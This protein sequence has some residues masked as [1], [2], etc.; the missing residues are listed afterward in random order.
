MGAQ[1]AGPPF[2]TG[3]F[4]TESPVPPSPSVLAVTNGDGAFIA[5]GFSRQQKAFSGKTVVPNGGLGGKAGRI[6]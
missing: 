5:K 2:R 4:L 6:E 3:E 1:A